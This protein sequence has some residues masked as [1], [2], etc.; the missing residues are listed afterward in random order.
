M[1]IQIL[2]NTLLKLLVRR[3]TNADREQITLQ[4]GELGFTTDTERL[5]IGNSTTPGGVIVGNK[6]KG[7]AANETTLTGVVT[8]DY[9]YNTTAKA[10]KVCVRGTGAEADDWLTVANQISAGN[11]TINIDSESKITVGSPAQFR[12]WYNAR[13]GEI[14][15]DDQ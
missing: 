4:S 15:L 10:L 7:S 2:E 1:A 13:Q 11:N 14:T 12:K 6:Y 3:G 9:Y 5:Y 8:G